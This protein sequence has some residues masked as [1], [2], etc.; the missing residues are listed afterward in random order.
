MEEK[1][2]K[3]T[4]FMVLI[5]T[6]NAISVSAKINVVTS[7][8]DLKSIAEYIGGDRVS[9]TSIAS[10]KSNPHFV[11]VLPSYMVIVSRAD[12]Y[13]KVGLELDFWAAPIID[14]SRNGKLIIIDC[15]QGVE[16]MEKPTAKVDASM[17]DVHPQGNPHYWLDPANAL[18]IAKNISKGLSQADPEGTSVYEGNLSGF[19]SELKTKME[20]WK[21]E[22]EP[23]NGMEI[24][25]YHN[26]WPYFSRAFG[27]KVV[28]FIEPRPGIEPTPAHT[29]ELIELVKSRGVKIIG[30]EPYFSDRAP[31]V[32]ARATGAVVVDLPPSVGGADGTTDYFSLIDTIINQLLRASH[33]RS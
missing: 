25:T 12:I 24:I 29:A 23:L 33:K 13:F 16:P 28:G 1:M 26:S 11:E 22:T 20:V 10:G 3:L 31:K 17:G 21:R 2:K 30:K 4:F 19:E 15:S 32:I 9:V 5:L 27:I 18:I 6:I 14:G 8:S 7:T